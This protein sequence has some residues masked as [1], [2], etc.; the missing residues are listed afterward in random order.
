MYQIKSKVS[1]RSQFCVHHSYQPQLPHAFPLNFDSL[2]WDFTHI[3]TPSTP[4]PPPLQWFNPRK[5]VYQ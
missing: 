1:E 2:P 4:S 3:A 5:H